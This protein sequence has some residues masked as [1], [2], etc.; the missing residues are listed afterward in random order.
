MRLWASNSF[1]WLGNGA[2]LSVEIMSQRQLKLVSVIKAGVGADRNEDEN[3][4]ER[5]QREKEMRAE[6]Y[7]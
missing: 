1:N 4:K 2:D 3:T 5:L 7:P 6:Q